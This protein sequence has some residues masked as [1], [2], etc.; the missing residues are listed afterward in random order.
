MRPSFLILSVKQDKIKISLAQFKNGFTAEGGESH[1]VLQHV[2][3]KIASQKTNKS[4]TG[5][6]KLYS[7]QKTGTQVGKK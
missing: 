7:I 3:N 4:K 1:H 2:K 6:D 5:K